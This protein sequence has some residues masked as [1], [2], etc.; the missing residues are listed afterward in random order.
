[1]ILIRLDDMDK[2]IINADKYANQKLKYIPHCY[3][4][5]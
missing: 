4:N 1:M 2:E 3:V 5:A